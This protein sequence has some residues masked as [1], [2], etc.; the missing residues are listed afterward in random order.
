[1]TAKEYLEQV[2]RFNQQIVSKKAELESYR[3]LSLSISGGGFEQ[4]Y[5]AS[6]NTS[7]PF[8][9]Y[10]NKIMDLEREIQEDMVTLGNMKFEVGLEIDKLECANER[11]VLRYRYL[12]L[13]T[14]GEVAKKLNYTKRWVLRIHDK[15]MFNFEKLEEGK[16]D[17]L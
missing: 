13:M 14:W 6:R 16:F 9:R 15:A 17:E 10:S 2:H 11:L 3:E 8:E 1:M 5:N 7:A 12:M 4:S